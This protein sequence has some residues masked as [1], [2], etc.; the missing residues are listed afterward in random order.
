M[1]GTKAQCWEDSHDRAWEAKIVLVVCNVVEEE[2]N[3]IFSDT[4]LEAN[5]LLKDLSS[6][7]YRLICS[8]VAL[9]WQK[10]IFKK[11]KKA[12]WRRL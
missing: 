3:A 5:S 8:T 4:T 7:P 9:S 11:K 2:K 6:I 1:A 10:Q 12:Q